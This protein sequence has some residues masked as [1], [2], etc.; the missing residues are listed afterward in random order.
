MKYIKYITII[1]FILSFSACSKKVMDKINK[2]L[3]DPTVVPAAT[4]LPSATVETVFGTT[5]TDL[6]WYSSMFVEQ[7]AGADEQF[8]DADRRSSLTAASLVDNSWN[9]IYDNLMILKDIRDKTAATGTEPNPALLGMSQV[10][11]AYNLAVATDMW[12]DIPWSEALMGSEN[13]HPKFDT[14]E[15]VYKAIFQLLNDAISN[16]SGA[17]GSGLAAQDLIYSGKTDKW[18]KAAWSLKARYFMHL[19]RV[20]PTAVDSVLACVPKGFSAASDAFIFDKYEATQIGSNP[21]WDFTYNERGDLVTGKTLYDLMNSRN[22]PR[23]NAYFEPVDDNG[24]ISAAPNGDADRTRAGNGLYS[25]SAIT[26]N[27]DADATVAT[28]LMTYHELLFLNAEAL[29]RKGSDFVPALKAAVEANFVFHG[30]TVAAADAY[31][32]TEVLT[33]VG[34]SLSDNLQEIMTQKYIAM[35]EQE[36][37]EVYNDYRRTGIPTMHNPNNDVASYGFPQRFPYPSSEV[38]ANPSNV[39]VV[40]I[41]KDKIWWAK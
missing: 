4:E 29:A 25:Y 34:T 39:P 40:N 33:R 19:Q 13:V 21:W 27:S 12:G 36:S 41:F 9:A 15:D 23:I 28:P 30:L 2:D 17:N 22:D 18:V 5:G 20:V 32:A 16:L 1:T 38:T 31:F 24:T 26:A 3:N 6:A 37:I 14:Q 8:Y 10:L 35:Y 11:T 7:S